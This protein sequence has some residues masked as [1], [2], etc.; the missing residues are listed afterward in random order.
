MVDISHAGDY[1]ESVAIRAVKEGNAEILGVQEREHTSAGFLSAHVSKR[2]FTLV[3]ITKPFEYGPI[4][5]DRGYIW[6]M[7]DLTAPPTPQEIEEK[8]GVTALSVK[9]FMQNFGN[10]YAEITRSEDEKTITAKHSFSTETLPI[11][12]LLE[13]IPSARHYEDGRIAD[14]PPEWLDSWVE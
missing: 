2:L 7:G 10:E 5:I 9:W 12:F 3:Q 13:W 8:H 11:Q 6:I 14:V 1:A 4:T